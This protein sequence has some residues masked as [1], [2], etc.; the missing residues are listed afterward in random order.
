MTDK[1][2]PLS[3]VLDELERSYGVDDVEQT[4]AEIEWALLMSELEYNR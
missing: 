2:L 4:D 1:Q 3:E